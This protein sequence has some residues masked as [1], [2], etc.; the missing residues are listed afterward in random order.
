MTD[1]G[2]EPV[3]NSMSAIGKREKEKKWWKKILIHFYQ[4][5]QTDKSGVP[6]KK[7]RAGSTFLGA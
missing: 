1:G 4:A 2:F 7:I 3:S 6:Q 5:S